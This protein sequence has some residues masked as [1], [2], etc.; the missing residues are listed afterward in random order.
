M[1]AEVI[2]LFPR[3]DHPVLHLCSLPATLSNGRI[4]GAKRKKLSQEE[5]KARKEEENLFS[6]IA[7]PPS[8]LASID[9]LGTD[10]SLQGSSKIV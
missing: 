3:V 4:F 7:G 1:S 10:N 8:M 2:S 5:M 6:K 9:V